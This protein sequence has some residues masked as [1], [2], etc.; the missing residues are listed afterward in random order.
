ML[1]GKNF[2]RSDVHV[3]VDNTNANARPRKVSVDCFRAQAQ[4][5]TAPLRTTPPSSVCWPCLGPSV[6][7]PSS[8]GR[9]DTVIRRRANTPA[10]LLVEAVVDLHPPAPSSQKSEER[11]LAK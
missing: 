3:R 8:A 4:A 2:E 7:G 5:S 10:V 6:L 11:S 1:D 9:S